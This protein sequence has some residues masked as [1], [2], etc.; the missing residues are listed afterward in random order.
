[1]KQNE[2]P[3]GFA[4]ILSIIVGIISIMVAIYLFS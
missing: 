2:E 4:A 3:D 1:M